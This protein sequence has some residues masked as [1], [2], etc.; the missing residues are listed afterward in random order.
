VNSEEKENELAEKY[1]LGRHRLLCPTYTG[2]KTNI[3]KNRM[4]CVATDNVKFDT[5]TRTYNKCD[6]QPYMSAIFTNWLPPVDEIPYQR[7]CVC[8]NTTNNSDGNCRC[9]SNAGYRFHN[10]TQTC[11]CKP[12]YFFLGNVCTICPQNSYYPVGT[13]K[14]VL[15]RGDS[16][17]EVGS[18]SVDQCYCFDGFA[19]ESQFAMCLIQSLFQVLPIDFESVFT[20]RAMFSE[21]TV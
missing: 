17:S 19:K 4:E 14:N 5:E 7:V 10:Q 2:V 8:P 9:D 12:G 20:E 21:E 13:T 15:C 18:D 11:Q 16:L 3:A 6:V 1:K